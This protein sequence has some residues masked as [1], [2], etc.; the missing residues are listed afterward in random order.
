MEKKT[1]IAVL[2]GGSSKERTISLKSG[3]AVYDALD[4]SKYDVMSYDPLNDLKALWNSRNHVDL[5]F[6]LLHGKYG[7]DGR[8]QG[9]LDLFHIPFVG[10][11][12]LS[13]AMAMNK[14][15]AKDVYRNVGLCVPKDVVLR[16]TEPFS[17]DDIK[18][19]LGTPV[20]VKPV[21]EG[22]SLGISIMESDSDILAGIEKALEFDSEILLEE[23]V[24]GREI[25]CAVLGR[26]NL[27]ALPLVEIV[28]E[29]DHRFFDFDAKY[30]PG[31]TT[32][33]CPAPISSDQAETAYGLAKKAHS[34][35]QCRDWSRTDMI[36][37]DEKFYLLET[38]TI[39]GM[40]ETSLVPLAAR[41][42]GWD[43][44]ELLDRMISTCLTEPDF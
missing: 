15:V 6:I 24:A 32:E 7:E 21:C 2:S 5:A 10:S 22:S 40:T 30:R 17:L 9:L 29:A 19:R 34:A 14:R 1:R 35:L 43:L 20:V 3:K 31:E 12:V 13:S 37:S 44:S 16:K 28:P 26:H 42:R 25:T 41:G 38:N 23:Y 4:K 27:E 33:L 39:P 8:I 36:L 11:G 18:K